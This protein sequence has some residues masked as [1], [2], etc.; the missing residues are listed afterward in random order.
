[1]K[2]YILILMVFALLF[3]CCKKGSA[4]K[5]EKVTSFEIFSDPAKVG[6]ET[7]ISVR[8]TN[9][10]GFLTLAVTIEY[11]SDVM[12]LSRIENGKDF[13]DYNFIPAKDMKSGCTT[14]WFTDNLQNRRSDG[15]LLKLYFSIADN[16]KIGKYP[17]AVLPINDGSVVDENKSPIAV[18][19]CRAYITIK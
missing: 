2:K 9:N 15:E 11:D 18:D 12:S 3:P 19:G 6:E 14:C 17:I 5:S 1:M 8:I 4:D 7:A 13:T 16:A 10:T